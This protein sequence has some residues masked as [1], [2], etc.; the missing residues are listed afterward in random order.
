MGVLGLRRKDGCIRRDEE[1]S[2]GMV[3]LEG[4]RR[5]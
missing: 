3:V 4:V 2:E 5:H 1:R